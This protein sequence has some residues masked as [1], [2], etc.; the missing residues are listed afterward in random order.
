[1]PCLAFALELCI[2]RCCFHAGSDYNTRTENFSAWSCKM[3]FFLHGSQ[4]RALIYCLEFSTRIDP[5]HFQYYTWDTNQESRL[6]NRYGL[7]GWSKVTH[8]DIRENSWH[9]CSWPDTRSFTLGQLM[10]EF[11]YFFFLSFC[12]SLLFPVTQW[13]GANTFM[14]LQHSTMGCWMSHL[15]E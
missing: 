11:P 1:M 4:K 13:V 9:E 8:I 7:G 2:L 12:P 10:I 3:I 5:R 15:L 14:Q 6:W